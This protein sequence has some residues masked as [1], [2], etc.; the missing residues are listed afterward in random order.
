VRI[1]VIVVSAVLIGAV[2][3]QFA[4]WVR[5]MQGGRMR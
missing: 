2:A 1:A 3:Y 5:W 4:R